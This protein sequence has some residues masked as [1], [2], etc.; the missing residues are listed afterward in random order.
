MAAI[1]NA[2][3]ITI[4][5]RIVKDV[6]YAVSANRERPLA[7]A[8]FSIACNYFRKTRLKTPWYFSCVA[9]GEMAERLKDVPR[10]HFICINQGHLMHAV[11]KSQKTGRT[12]NNIH[13]CVE[14]FVIGDQPGT[15]DKMEKEIEQAEDI[16]F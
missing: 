10:G 16:S 4:S 8:Y 9:F 2:N 12:Y 3:S 13:I 15:T 7:R 5:G 14:D 11:Y 1:R 6:Q